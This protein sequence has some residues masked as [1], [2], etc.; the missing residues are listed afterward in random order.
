MDQGGM[1]DLA[2]AMAEGMR[3]LQ[4][5]AQDMLKSMRPSQVAHK[6]KASQQR[7]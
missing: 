6:V 2:Y 7:Y 5:M 3:C 1:D 4:K